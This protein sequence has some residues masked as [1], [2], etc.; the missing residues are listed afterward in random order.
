MLST[1]PALVRGSAV[2][3]SQSRGGT[4]RGGELRD[5]SHTEFKDVRRD[6]G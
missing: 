4:H 3:P 6:A 5:I 1:D 2:G